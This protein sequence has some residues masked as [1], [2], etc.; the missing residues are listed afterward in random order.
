MELELMVPCSL[1]HVVVQLA[2]RGTKS[3]L[4]VFGHMGVS[5]PSQIRQFNVKSFLSLVR[6]FLICRYFFHHH[7]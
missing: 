2:G 7:H 5:P 6:V 1:F 3:H 4:L